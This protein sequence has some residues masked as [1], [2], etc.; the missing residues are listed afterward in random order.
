MNEADLANCFQLVYEGPR[1][2]S[3][4]TLQKIKGVFVADLD[5]PVSEAQRIIEN[6]PAIVSTAGD[7]AQ[8]KNPFTLLKNAGAKV[9][10]VRPKTPE[11][12][13][14]EPSQQA[15]PATGQSR[16]ESEISYLF[17]VELPGEE[18]A[19]QP[20]KKKKVYSIDLEAD[21][22]EPLFSFYGSSPVNMFDESS[23]DSAQPNLPQDNPTTTLIDEAALAEQSEKGNEAHWETE[24]APP[25]P[26]GVDE[27]VPRP[28]ET[29]TQP[30]DK[31]RDSMENQFALT[32]D[33]DSP[34]PAAPE[35]D[36]DS[37]KNQNDSPPAPIFECEP[38]GLSLE[39]AK[40]EEYDGQKLGS[41]A[42][43]LAVEDK[44]SSALFPTD[45]GNAPSSKAIHP[46]PL[47][48]PA[49]P[50]IESAQTQIAA[51]ASSYAPAEAQ[52]VFKA[53]NKSRWRLP[54]DIIVPIIMGSGILFAAN[55][56]YFSS[57]AAP[58]VLDEQ[59]D[60]TSPDTSQQPDE[61]DQLLKQHGIVPEAD[62]AGPEREFSKYEV[63]T[64]LQGLS[65]G[66]VIST[67]KEA[68]SA[69]TIFATTPPPPALTKEE[70]VNKK[71]R[72]P[73][74]K[75][76]ES[77]NVPLT[78]AEDGSFTGEGPAFAYVDYDHRQNRM[79]GSLRITARLSPDRLSTQVSLTAGNRQMP[80]LGTE[81]GLQL[82]PK[83]DG[84]FEFSFSGKALAQKRT[85]SL[86]R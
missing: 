83:E 13:P 82:I 81:T 31:E 17:E 50:H 51:S 70:I 21:A 80:D 22:S 49:P 37:S 1:D 19:A 14:Q 75:K 67:S 12:S 11:V 2:D 16:P 39:K 36:S 60:L 38:S 58:K 8:L 78:P 27:T 5:L 61:I 52:P 85:F 65:W 66:I 18:V 23:A 34:L 46:K 53:G 57:G 69:A 3:P 43:E 28:A 42:V 44:P 9:L 30:L 76:F 48:P 79:V 41:P 59:I 25:S 77:R 35:N 62:A 15:P 73:W 20:K 55:W 86:E 32:L 40:S 68:L 72:A 54:Y 10:L 74:L 47:P 7:E 84:T 26:A 24:A 45:T 4:R 64:D 63:Q 6:I 33:E 56:Y 71:L 29:L